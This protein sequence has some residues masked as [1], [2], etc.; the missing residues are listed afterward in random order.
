MKARTTAEKTE[1]VERVRDLV[2]EAA[3]ILR[4]VFPDD[5]L[6]RRAFV[7][8]LEIVAGN[9]HGWL[10]RDPNLGDLLERLE[11]ESEELAEMVDNALSS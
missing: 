6:V 8:Q 5:E 11:D 10:S 4:E 2:L 3:Q 9:D 1:A 7:A